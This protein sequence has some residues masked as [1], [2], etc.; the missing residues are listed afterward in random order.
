M[1]IAPN[2]A[3]LAVKDVAAKVFGESDGPLT[4]T[5]RN[6][7]AGQLV[8]L[9]RDPAVASGKGYVLA[10]GAEVRVSLD[11]GETLYAICASGKET[12]LEVI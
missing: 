3:E 2:V 11:P 12:T 6:K 7:T 5:V 8:T 10:I 9:A 4:R 1:P